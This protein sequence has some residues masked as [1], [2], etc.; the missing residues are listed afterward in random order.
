M[1]GVLKES[2]DGVMALQLSPQATKDRV[3]LVVGWQLEDNVCVWSEATRQRGDNFIA[4]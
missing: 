3:L 1:L 4:H 2:G